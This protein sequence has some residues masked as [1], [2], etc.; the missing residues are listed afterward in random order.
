MFATLLSIHSMKQ[1]R[2]TIETKGGKKEKGSLYAASKDLAVQDL[3]KRGELILSVE[4]L[5]ARQ[6]VFL[7][8][9]SLSFQDKLLFTSHLST[10]L[11]AGITITESLQIILD[12]ATRQGTRLMYEDLIRRVNAG[13]TLSESLSYY[14]KLFSQIFINMIGV[15]EKSGSLVEVLGYLK[16][17]LEK[18]NE[19]RQKVV[20]ALVY[21]GVIVSMTLLM[22]FGITF[23]IMPKILDIFQSFDVTLPLPTRILI[24]FT[25]LITGQPLLFFSVLGL[26]VGG[27]FLLMRSDFFQPI[28]HRVVV[29]VPVFGRIWIGVNVARFCRSLNSLLKAGV[30]IDK[31]LEITGSMFSDRSYRDLAL[32][33]R[34]KVEQGASL[35]EALRGHERQI[36]ILVIKMFAVGEKTGRLEETTEHLASLYEQSVDNITRNLSVL[37]EP[38]LLVFM[39]L[40]VGSVALA[41][42]LPIYQLP[43]LIQG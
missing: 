3:K 18:E 1:F 11:G 24:G 27:S 21:P 33:A 32:E 15:G 23:F 14:P 37:L 2:Y 34:K 40:L 36:P 28:W 26:F 38:L 25:H 9:P 5:E 17:Q 19:L 10:M 20:A 6:N 29:H 43:N 41:V 35:E 30:S 39:G 8:G 16:T 31:A 12:Q 13:Q 7:S 42:I 4:E 22:V